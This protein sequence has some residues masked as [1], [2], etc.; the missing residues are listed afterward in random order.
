MAPA[1]KLPRESCNAK[2]MINP[3]TPR[4]ASIGARDIPIC[5]NA[6]RIPVAIT[7]PPEIETSMF[8]SKSDKPREERSLAARTTRL[9][10]RAR[11]LNTNNTAINISRRNSTSGALA[12]MALFTATHESFSTVNNA[13]EENRLTDILAPECWS[14]VAL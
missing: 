10:T 3:A 13:F 1:A 7:A 11:I 4:P 6:M 14:R 5:D 8:F 9:V 2:P 12:P